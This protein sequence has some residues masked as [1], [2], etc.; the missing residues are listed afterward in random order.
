MEIEKNQGKIN[1][2]FVG[3]SF[4]KNLHLVISLQIIKFPERQLLIQS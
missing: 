1:F 2:R 3:A 4:R